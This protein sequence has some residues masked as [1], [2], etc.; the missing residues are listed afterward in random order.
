MSSGTVYDAF[1]ARL[2]SALGGSY[3]IRDWE[4]IE[5][6][7]QRGTA[8]WIAV[9]D[10]PA[11]PLLTSIGTPSQ[12]WIEYNGVIDV[13]MFVPS[14]GGLSAART[15]ADAV[16]NALQFY[17]FSMS[18]GQS[19][20]TYGVGSAGPGVIHDGLW[21]SM[22]QSVSYQHRYAVATAAE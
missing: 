11:E 9:D 20:R 1:K 14:T 2:I 5:V 16:S 3:P 15:M 18:A 22:M 6:A 7:L 12:N 8:P 17:H 21:H 19:L 13:H 4:E 10:S